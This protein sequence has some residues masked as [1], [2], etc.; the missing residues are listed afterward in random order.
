MEEMIR[1]AAELIT[2]SNNIFF[3]TGAG[4]STSAGVPDFRSN[5]GLYQQIKDKYNIENPEVVFDI[6]F[7]KKTPELF[8]EVSK[9]LLNYDIEPTETHRFIARIEE[10]GK[11]SL[12]VTQN[13]DML[14]SKAGSK[15]I[16]ECHGSYNIGYCQNCGMEYTFDDYGTTILDGQI[17]KCKCKGVIKPSVVFFGE[18]LP[19][20]FYDI[21][22][23]P[24]D[25]DLLVVM[26]TSLTVQPAASLALKFVTNTKSII[27]NRDPTPFDSR[28]NLVINGELDKIVD[29][30]WEFIE[31]KK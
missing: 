23:E 21:Y 7:F 9:N 24:P 19:S 17:P 8:Y 15:N 22:D 12:L 5:N 4:V 11:M 20:K 26:G 10:M 25:V 16:F 3:F 28:F 6:S 18:Q 1:K 2:E 30:I 31:G 29:K 27:I 13:I 14:H